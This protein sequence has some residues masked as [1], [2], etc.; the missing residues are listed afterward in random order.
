MFTKED[1]DIVIRRPTLMSML[2]VATIAWVAGGSF[3]AQSPDCR[4][5]STTSM[6][7]EARL[8]LRR[9]RTSG[10]VATKL[11]CLRL[12]SGLAARIGIPPDSGEALCKCACDAEFDPPMPGWQLLPGAGQDVAA[13]GTEVWLVGSNP[14]PGGFGIYRWNGT[15]WNAEP[16]GAVAIALDE[17]MRPWVANDRGAIYRWNGSTWIGMPGTALDVGGGTSG[18]WAV[19][20]NP[21][22]GGFGIYRWAGT[23]WAPMPGGAVRIAVDQ[24]GT[25]WVVNDQHAVY[26]WNGATWIMMLGAAIDV[27]AGPGGVWVVGTDSVPGGF[28]IYHWDGAGWTA[29]PGGAVRI[30]VGNE[31]WVVNDHQLIWSWR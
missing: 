14:V 30:S 19:G 1:L 18:M 25:P 2:L 27:G 24:D 17:M 7:W 11:G 29:M 15:N 12:G 20:T 22:P 8:A 4:I 5:W 21:V 16:G 3:Q 13:R 10:A 6:M 28:G 26:R 31:P 9:A 23:G